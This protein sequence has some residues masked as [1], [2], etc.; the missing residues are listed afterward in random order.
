MVEPY[1]PSMGRREAGAAGEHGARVRC[2]RAAEAVRE[3][4]EAGAFAEHGVRTRRLRDA[5]SEKILRK[6]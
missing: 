2:V 3:R 4:G 5:E 1:A 6:F